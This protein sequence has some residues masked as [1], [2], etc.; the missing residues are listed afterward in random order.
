MVQDSCAIECDRLCM[1]YSFLVKKRGFCKDGTSCEA[2]CV[3]EDKKTV[4]PS[5]MLWASDHECVSL[6]ECLCVTEDGQPV[7]VC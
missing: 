2:G 5:N 4:C 3:S 7:K 6:D 1:Y